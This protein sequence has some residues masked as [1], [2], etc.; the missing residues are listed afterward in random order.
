MW[1]FM[2][3]EEVYLKC[4]CKTTE[5]IPEINDYFSF[6][7]FRIAFFHI[8]G[9]NGKWKAKSKQQ[10]RPYLTKEQRKPNASEELQK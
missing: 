8:I 6:R 2:Y 1:V 5:V 10:Q 9:E 3:L 4:I 7:C